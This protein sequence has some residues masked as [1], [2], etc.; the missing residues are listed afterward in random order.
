MCVLSLIFNISV[1]NIN[2]VVNAERDPAVATVLW[3]SIPKSIRFGNIVSWEKGQ[4][5]LFTDSIKFLRR[6]YFYFAI[7]LAVMRS[8]VCF[9][10]WLTTIWSR[11]SSKMTSSA[12]VGH[13]C[14]APPLVDASTSLQFRELKPYWSQWISRY[15]RDLSICN[16]RP[17]NH[18]I[19]PPN[20]QAFA[21]NDWRVDASTP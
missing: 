11:V 17:Y 14:I 3:E 16:C 15:P 5:D 4:W 7:R 19:H 21:Y 8:I 1:H 9:A 20:G 18:G 2:R 6:N 10:I 12:A 13:V